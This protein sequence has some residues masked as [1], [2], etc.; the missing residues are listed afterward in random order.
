MGSLSP[1]FSSNR[2][3]EDESVTF[4]VDTNVLVE[5]QSLERINWRLLCPNAKSVR[6]VVPA[7]VIREMD[8]HKRGTGRLRRRAFEFNKLL[9]VIEDG[10]GTSAILQ[11]NHVDLSLGLMERYARS[12][13]AEGK[14]S[15]EVADDLIVAEAVKFSKVHGEAV[16]LADDNN[17]R[18][19]AREMGIRVARPAEKWRRTEPRDWRDARIEKLE[20]QVG[21]MPRLFLSLLAEE[22]DAVVFETLD[23]QA[24]PNEFLERVGQAILEGNPGVNRDEL[25]RRHNLQDVQNSLSLHLDSF[26]VTVEE[27]DQYC[28]EYQQYRRKVL[29]WSR[30][31]PERLNKIGFMTPVWLEVANN[32]EA[33]AEDVEI[34]L[35]TSEGYGF[36]KRDLVESFLQMEMEA[37]EP[38]EGIGRFPNVQDLFGQQELHGRSPFDFYR[39]STPDLDGRVPR[40]SYECERFRHGASTTLT[41]SMYKRPDAPLGGELVVRASSASIVDPVEKRYPIRTK[42]EKDSMNFKRYVRRRLFF[43]P[44]DSRDVVTNLLAEY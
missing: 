2:L 13:L 28:E 37:P 35:S 21:A 4:V 40:I 18:R 30:G 5:F 25:I 20:R 29:A 44:D 14:L 42:A 6:I 12:E 41:C 9:Q 36:L 43:F 3:I 15:F 1:V 8:K 26:S 16:F 27:V 34:T 39:R 7:T 24:V 32:G 38:P 11:N 10:D 23:E 33:F 19:A 31:L 22:E 17:A